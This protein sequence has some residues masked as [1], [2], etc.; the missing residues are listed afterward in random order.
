MHTQKYPTSF[1]YQVFCFNSS[2]TNTWL[3]QFQTRLVFTVIFLTC[4]VSQSKDIIYI[5]SIGL[6]VTSIKEMLSQI[7]ILFMIHKYI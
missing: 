2:P 4:T 6:Q 3:I 1:K 5:I 7:S